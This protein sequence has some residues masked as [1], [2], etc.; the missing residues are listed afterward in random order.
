MSDFTDLL[1]KIESKTAIVAIAGLGT[2]GMAMAQLIAERGYRIIGYDKDFSKIAELS[3]MGLGEGL[4]GAGTHPSI[5]A[6]ADIILVC[7]PTGLDAQGNPDI[8]QVVDVLVQIDKLEPRR[9]RLVVIEST[10]YPG[11]TEKLRFD[12]SRW[13]CYSPQRIDPGRDNW[14]VE[15]TIKLLAGVDAESWQLART[16]YGSIL[17]CID[18]LYPCKPIEAEF[19]KLYENVYR[20]VNIALVNEMKV[21]CNAAGVDAWEV[22]RLAQTKPF[23][24]GPFTPGP[25]VGG[26]CIPMAPKFMLGE[27]VEDSLLGMAWEI[28]NRTPEKVVEGIVEKLD[29][30]GGFKNPTR[31]LFLGVS[32]KS[33]SGDVRNSPVVEIMKQLTK[34]GAEVDYI[35]PH[36]DRPGLFD[37]VGA[38][39]RLDERGLMVEEEL[40]QYDAVVYAVDHDCFGYDK[41]GYGGLNQQVLD[42]C[43]LVIDLC[44]ATRGMKGKAKVVKL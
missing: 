12:Q 13:L 8:S 41:G 7:V 34:W 37:G 20:A 17:E 29:G 4:K 28:N 11:A 9:K 5:M 42:E 26:S 35:D 40:R 2:V 43:R 1:K 10:L 14:T 21:L 36:V 44:D 3:E 23:G 39:W 27:Y 30:W 31:I 16:F 32:Y 38:S 6:D 19:A 18:L 22:C 15:N 24:W 25:G 33:N